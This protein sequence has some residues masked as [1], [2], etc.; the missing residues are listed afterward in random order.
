LKK[1]I[2]YTFPLA[3]FFVFASFSYANEDKK[4]PVKGVT[5]ASFETDVLKSGKPVLVDFWAGWCPCCNLLQ[6]TMGKFA[7]DYKGK[8]TVVRMN[9]EDN[10]ARPRKLGVVAL[11][12]VIVFNNGKVVKKWM[13][14]VS[15]SDVRKEIDKVLKSN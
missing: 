13:G 8:L 11:P 2:Q 7:E 15:E 10:P 9:V 12:A 5:D 1:L 4:E 6:P 3:I 14:N